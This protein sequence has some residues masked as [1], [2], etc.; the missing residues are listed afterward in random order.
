MSRLACRLRI[1][2][3]WLFNRRALNELRWKFGLQP[4][5]TWNES[6]F[7]GELVDKWLGSVGGKSRLLV[8]VFTDEDHLLEATEAVR[9]A[10]FDIHDVYT[11]YAVHGMDDAMGLRRSRL[12][13]V[14]FF[15]GLFAGAFGAFMQYYTNAI[16]WPINVGGK[17]PWELH[18][19]VPVIFEM[20]VLIAG[21]TTMVALFARSKLFPGKKAQLIVPGITDDK[22]AIALNH[23]S[24]NF[25][26]ERARAL[27]ARFHAERVLDLGG[28]S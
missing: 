18:A 9:K 15:A 22:F 17:N 16:D 21:L 1:L 25:D 8:G 23:G 10:G 27:F 19:Y 13:W 24:A 5:H 7:K 28:L 6:P 12:T 11:P 4:L 3:M 26:A 20:T 14:C 2:G